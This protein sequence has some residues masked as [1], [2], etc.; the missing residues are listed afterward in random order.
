MTPE[1]RKAKSRLWRRL[2]EMAARWEK[3][4][5]IGFETAARELREHL[6][7]WRPH[8]AGQRYHDR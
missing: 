8:T 3:Q 2:A 6:E 4:D 1:E 7:T 5:G